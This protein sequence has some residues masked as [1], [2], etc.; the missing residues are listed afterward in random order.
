MQSIEVSRT[1]LLRW[2]TGAS[3]ALSLLSHSHVCRLRPFPGKQY[4]LQAMAHLSSKRGTL[5][6]DGGWQPS[7]G[8]N[9]LLYEVSSTFNQHSRKNESMHYP[10]FQFNDQITADYRAILIHLHTDE[11]SSKCT[12]RYQRTRIQSYWVLPIGSEQSIEESKA[13]HYHDWWNRR[14]NTS[15]SAEIIVYLLFHTT[16]IATTEGK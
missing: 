10:L 2:N 16:S 1:K 15:E 12:G 3:N 8:Q 14:S 4:L 13:A 6:S 11:C 5:S 9:P 7:I